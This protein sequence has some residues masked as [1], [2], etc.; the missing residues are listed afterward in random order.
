MTDSAELGAEHDAENLDRTWKAILSD[1]FYAAF[2]DLAKKYPR[3]MRELLEVF[4]VEPHVIGQIL[5][6]KA[7]VAV[8]RALATTLPS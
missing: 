5:D 3:K 8:L 6:H 4:Q 7:T 2:F 1:P